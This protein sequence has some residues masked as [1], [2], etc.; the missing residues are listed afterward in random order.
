MLLIS[1]TGVEGLDLKGLRFGL[2]LEPYWHDA[3][4]GQFAAR[5]IRYK[6]HEH[7]PPEERDCQLVIYLSDY[8]EKIAKA[9]ALE[10]KTTDVDLYD[11]SLS[12]KIILDKF[13][14]AT[15]ESS[16]DC[17]I[18]HATL[19]AAIQKKI[20]CLLCKPTGKQLYNANIRHDFE[21]E[22]P[23]QKYSVSNDTKSITAKEI[24][25]D[26][27]KFYY[28]YEKEKGLNSLV[29]Y[30]YDKNLDG[31]IPIRANSPYYP[32]IMEQ[33]LMLLT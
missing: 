26:G 22:R 17:N 11:E 14:L 3:R 28:T 25:V 33:L 15:I 4:R 10:E 23:C 2:M 29:V 6:S 18:H 8:P 1:S 5:M 9:A 21:Q 24:I 27:N 19:D 13:F 31:H 32:A 20:N 16:I 30:E 12:S 7:L